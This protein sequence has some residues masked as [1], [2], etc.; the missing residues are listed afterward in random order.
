MRILGGAQ[1]VTGVTG[2][3]KALSQSWWRTALVLLVSLLCSSAWIV[4]SVPCPAVTG[5]T[6]DP[7]AQSVHRAT[8]AH[9]VP[10]APSV[11]VSPVSPPVL[12]SSAVGVWPKATPQSH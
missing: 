12:P 11:P 5:V 8:S 7:G 2:A 3:C 9:A 10:A 1:G 4:P 6:A